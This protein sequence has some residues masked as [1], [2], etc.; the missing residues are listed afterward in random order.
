MHRTAEA[1]RAVERGV[2][3]TQFLIQYHPSSQLGGKYLYMHMTPLENVNHVLH[4][5]CCKMQTLVQG[6]GLE[7]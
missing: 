2:T 6:G 3:A 7:R 4:V 1:V 5:G